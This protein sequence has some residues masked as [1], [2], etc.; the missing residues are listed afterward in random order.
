MYYIGI[1][2]SRKRS[3]RRHITLI[4]LDAIGK[5]GDITV[6]SGG[7]MGIDSEAYD[8]CMELGVPILTIPPK[9]KEYHIKGNDIFFERNDLIAQKSV[10]L[11]AFP[12]NR[13]GGSMNTV[14]H[15][16]RLKG[17]TNLHVYD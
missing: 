12:L 11:H 15:F 16:I 8:V 4:L 7:A 17:K 3:E 9:R 1:V 10:E 14:G 13:S 6:V 2:G 5:H